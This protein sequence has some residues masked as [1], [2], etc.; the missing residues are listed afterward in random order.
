MTLKEEVK[1]LAGKRRKF[2]LLRV[3]DL[4]T[5]S[6]RKLCG[7]AKGTYHSWLQNQEFTSLY[8]RRDEFAAI[9]KQEAIQLLRRDNQLEAVLLESD[10]IAKMKAELASGEYSLIRSHLAREVYSKLITDLDVVPQT[11]LLSWQ[12]RV[13]QFITG[14][15][16]QIGEGEV[17]EEIVE[18]EFHQIAE[19]EVVSE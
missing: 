2:F 4:D 17:Q 7:V 8:R 10:I 11:P 5:D 19:E 9:Y 1:T 14:A 18:G 15:P 3:A 6:A 13:T 16:G 12:Q